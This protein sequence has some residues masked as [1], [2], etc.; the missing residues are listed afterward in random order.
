[1]EWSGKSI[2]YKFNG[3]LVVFWNFVYNNCRILE[4]KRNVML[5]LN[6]I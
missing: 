4:Y 1:M 3:G 5:V 2:I 6:V